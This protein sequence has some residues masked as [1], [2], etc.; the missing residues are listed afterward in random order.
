VSHHKDFAGHEIEE[1][2]ETL[3]H[4]EEGGTDRLEDLRR[5]SD[6][7]DLDAL[8]GRARELGLAEVADDGVILT[9]QG[10]ELAER[11]VRRH[12]L[13]ELLLS[14]VL[15]V[16]DEQAVERSACVMEHV[17]G[18]AVTDSVCA[19]LGH[20][21]FCPHGRPIPSG[22]CCRSFSNAI[23]PLVQPLARLAVGSTAR[24]VYIVPR[25]AERLVRLSTLGVVP[26]ATLK[27]QQ[28]APATVL[29]I[30][31]TTLAVDPEISGE[32]FVKRFE[33]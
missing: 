8:L 9:A 15:E 12:R 10:R 6:A 24:I 4:L 32:I 2:A 5:E 20:P 7:A 22:R 29:R 14:T 21:K 1:L 13:A 25:D 28:K 31:E 27:L 33:E 30:G 17:L 16:G 26:G 3:W 11:Q 19:F 18:A 23:E